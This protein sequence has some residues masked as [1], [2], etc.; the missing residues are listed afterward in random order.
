MKRVFYFNIT[1]RCNHRCLYCFSHTTADNSEQRQDIDLSIFKETLSRYKVG[2]GDRIVLNGGEP[3]LHKNFRDIVD[4][5]LKAC[6]EVVL[7]SNGVAFADLGFAKEI[8]SNQGLRI[9][10]PIHGDEAIHDYITQR[11]GS[12]RKTSLAISNISSCGCDLCLEPK[13]IVSDMMAKKAFD[14]RKYLLSTVNQWE[15]I[16]DVVI[17][18]QVNTYN[19]KRNSFCSSD[20]VF[21]MGYAER[22]IIKNCLDIWIKFYDLALCKCSESFRERFDGECVQ[23]DPDYE[24]FFVDGNCLPQLRTLPTAERF[25]DCKCCPLK[26]V[27]TSICNSYC[28]TRIFKNRIERV[29][30]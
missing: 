28:V 5:A 10:I 17:A 22:E 19:A 20:S 25:S 15:T 29:L 14:T 24:I 18:G 2:V 26:Y 3:T 6:S 11:C 4:V 12:W 7:Y 23:P 1:Y 16:Y 27:C 21:R 30:E 9:T 13:F 8:F